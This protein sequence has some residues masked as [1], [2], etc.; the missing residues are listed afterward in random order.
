MMR[1]VRSPERGG[2]IRGSFIPP[3]WGGLTS[4]C[5]RPATR[6]ISCRLNRAGGRV[7]RG[8]MRRYGEQA[9]GSEGSGWRKTYHGSC[10]F[11]RDLDA[12]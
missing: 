11:L 3:L 1:G 9:Q 4:A 2:L 5:T 7:M 6:I 8:V 12:A 10:R